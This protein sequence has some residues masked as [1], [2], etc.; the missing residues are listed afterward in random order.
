MHPYSDHKE[1][2]VEFIIKVT[3]STLMLLQQL[4]EMYHLRDYQED[5]YHNKNRICSNSAAS[6]TIN[7]ADKVQLYDLNLTL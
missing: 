3:L 1:I 6:E 5:L 7:K 4:K 2:P